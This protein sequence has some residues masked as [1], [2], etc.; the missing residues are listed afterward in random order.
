[1]ARS[2]IP[3][4]ARHR[5]ASA[6]ADWIA[7]SN[8]RDLAGWIPKFATAGVGENLAET[9]RCTPG[10]IVDFAGRD[11]PRHCITSSGPTIEGGRWVRAEALVLGDSV[12][13][14]IIDGDTVL[15]YGRPRLA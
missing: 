3:R 7:L 8:G 6:A 10:T 9:F 5:L 1:M 2:P 14:H 12:V 11:D 13:K 15:T 4:A